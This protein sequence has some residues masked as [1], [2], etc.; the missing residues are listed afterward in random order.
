MPTNRLNRRTF[1]ATTT[2]WPLVARAQRPS[3][4][5]IGYLSNRAAA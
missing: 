4:P 1:L 5:V 2:A 3:P